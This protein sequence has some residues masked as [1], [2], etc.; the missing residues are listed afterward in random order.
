[1]LSKIFKKSL[2]LSAVLIGVNAFEPASA[3]S[4]RIIAIPDAVKTELEELQAAE[5]VDSVFN[6]L[7]PGDGVTV[8]S[9]R[10]GN[11]IS[12]FNI[13]DKPRYKTL[14]FV[15]K[16]YQED[17]LKVAAHLR[18][19]SKEGASEHTD[20]LAVLDSLKY[21]SDGNQQGGDVI[22]VVSPLHTP[23]SD[24]AASM[25]DKN[26]RVL[27]PGDG[28]IAANK[29]LSP[30]GFDA[31]DEGALDGY[32]IHICA[33]R[34][35][36][37]TAHEYREIADQ[38]GQYIRRRDGALVTFTSDFALCVDRFLGNVSEPMAL[39]PFDPELP[40][41]WIHYSKDGSFE[42][43]SIE[44]GEALEDVIKAKERKFQETI[45][46]LEKTIDRLE[47]EID[48]YQELLSTENDSGAIGQF[49]KFWDAPHPD[50]KNITVQTG[51]RYSG[52][53]PP[54]WITSWC[55]FHRKNAVGA[56][57]KVDLGDAA[58]G[59]KPIWHEPKSEVL[60]DARI[61]QH[62]FER[63]KTACLFPENE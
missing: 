23:P 9:S 59:Q 42:V 43:V 26:G 46:E 55:Y 58:P 40:P 36:E 13:D 21:R 49:S 7:G 2:L 61:T 16:A 29:A 11:T 34:P 47:A 27:I 28:L 54:E 63:A 53:M 56:T 8:L 60:A 48:T 41:S 51:V 33:L 4:N 1:M 18:E 30:Y 5:L 52:D 39:Q 3:D 35:D 44:R 32:N 50:N 14:S 37:L 22:I 17:I 19:F 24:S 62:V 31:T 15:L 57:L 20:L 10:S 25:V 38:F 45:R 6:D 12:S